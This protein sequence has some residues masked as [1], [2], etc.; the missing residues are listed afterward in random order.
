MALPTW[1][2]MMDS[3]NKQQSA[4]YATKMNTNVEEAYL[5]MRKISGLGLKLGVLFAQGLFGCIELTLNLST[6]RGQGLDLVFLSCQLILKNR[7]LVAEDDRLELEPPDFLIPRNHG[8][9]VD[10]VLMLEL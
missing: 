6:P 9:L 5:K 4:C 10:G 8:C 7:L 1:V 3:R 2:W